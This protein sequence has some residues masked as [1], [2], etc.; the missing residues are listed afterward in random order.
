MTPQ[1]IVNEGMFANDAFSQWLGITLLHIEEGYVKIQM[2]VR[3]EM[4]NG[5]GIAHGGITYS[6]ADSCLAFASNA[7]GKHA[8]SIETAISHTQ[9][10]SVGDILTAEAQLKHLSK[11]LG[12]YE[13]TVTNQSQQS[14]ALFKG[15]VYRKDTSW[16]RIS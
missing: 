16:E 5:F 8:V 9:A 4:T 13:V 15:T 2:T 10:V 12:I 7:H 6:L 3:K 14:V 11:R 1:E